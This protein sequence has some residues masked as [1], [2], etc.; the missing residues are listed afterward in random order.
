MLILFWHYNQ[1]SYDLIDSNRREKFTRE[2]VIRQNLQSDKERD[3][4]EGG[5]VR[6]GERPRRWSG[7]RRSERTPGTAA[8]PPWPGL[9]RRWIWSGAA[10]AR[11]ASLRR[12]EA[13][14][15]G[16]RDGSRN[17]E[18]G[19]EKGVDGV[20]WWFWTVNGSAYGR[21][22]V[23]RVLG[24]HGAC[25]LRFTNAKVMSNTEKQTIKR[26]YTFDDWSY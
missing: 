20:V 26:Q 5:S 1:L 2:R 3:G 15:M 16:R 22:Y 17:S 11:P 10:S 18:T 21:D 14:A 24:W 19:R 23:S 4:E 25:P 7:R 6:G 9:A 13:K 12:S 8:A